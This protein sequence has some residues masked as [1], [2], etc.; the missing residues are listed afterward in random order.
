MSQGKR[1]RYQQAKSLADRIAKAI[2]D[3][4]ERLEIAGSIRRQQGY[5]GDIEMVAIPI[6]HP[7]MFEDVPGENALLT[8][9]NEL[10]LEGRLVKANNGTKLPKFYVP[11]V[12]NFTLE[13]RIADELSWP[14]A[15]AITTGP[16]TFSKKLVTKISQGGFLPSDCQIT[17]GWHVVRDGN[18][19]EFASE[20]EFLEFCE[21]GWIEPKSRG[22]KF[23][24]HYS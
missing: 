12:D 9:L 16:E 21:C 22:K 19:L 17:H 10:V 6:Y 20:R 11:V 24:E 15:L 7:S 23:G 5:V 3:S 18:H 1:I 8:R 4:C 2:A 14:V 13:V